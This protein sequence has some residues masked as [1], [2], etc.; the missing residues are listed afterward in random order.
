MKTLTTD[1]GSSSDP[2]VNLTTTAMNQV[3]NGK[4]KSVV[5]R[6]V[7]NWRQLLASECNM[8]L[9]T[10]LLNRN[11]STRDIHSFVQKQADIRKV[12]K[13][14]DKPM[15]RAAMRSKLNDAAAFTMRQRR[16]V[17]SLKKDLLKATGNKKFVQ[18]RIVKQVR[19]KLFEER[20]MQLKN[21]EDKLQRYAKLQSEMLN[22]AQ[23]QSV[24]L[25]ASLEM[26]RSVKA[27]GP[28]PTQEFSQDPPRVYD[29]SIK[30]DDDE[31]SILS[32]GPKF[33]VRQKL[34]RED[35]RVQLEKMS[36][37]Q[38]F[39][40]DGLDE[41]IPSQNSHSSS[42]PL[43]CDET[44]VGPQTKPES[45]WE[46]AERKS[47]L[48]YDFSEGVLDPTKLRA[49]NYKFNRSSN[50]PKPSSATVEAKHELRKSESLQIFDKTVSINPKS[51]SKVPF[52]CKSNLNSNE[53]KGLK[54]LQKKVAAGD[55][56][57]CESDKSAKLCVLTKEQ[58]LAAGFEHCKDDLEVS[59]VD[60][61]RLQR[62]VNA[63]VEWLHEIFDTGSFW[64][65]EDRII[66]RSRFPS[67]PF[68]A[69][70]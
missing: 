53:L 46:W 67:S 3:S 21:D 65:H 14:L 51:K 58:Y 45:S 59:A 22:E 31:L 17:N 16:V 40:S 44:Q 19:D 24:Q 9:F 18:K 8:K 28:A 70:T 57:V 60:V 27:F 66:I 61:K 7:R 39:S 34:V 69:V 62:Y 23:P 47:Q 15:T 1:P 49:T 48:V 36:C 63:H 5:G 10:N 13:G 56:V 37:K 38:K 42:V 11:I 26:F 20:N 2:S 6:L 32:K 52:A 12:H 4:V 50:L 29:P 35:F 41:E 33:A 64:N 25:P 54:S 68:K 43:L 55:L 30:L